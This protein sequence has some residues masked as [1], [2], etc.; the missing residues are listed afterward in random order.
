MV[1]K[2]GGVCE[3]SVRTAFQIEKPQGPGILSGA[4]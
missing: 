3:G 1:V 4:P 2:I